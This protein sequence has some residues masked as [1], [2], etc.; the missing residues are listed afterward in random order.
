MI[1]AIC[2]NLEHPGVNNQFL[3]NSKSSLATLYN[4]ES[5]LEK[6][7]A[8]RAFELMLHPA[9]DLLAVFSKEEYDAFR[10]QVMSLILATD[11]ASHNEYV[12]S[13]QLLG[14]TVCTCMCMESLLKRADL[15]YIYIYMYIYIHIYM[16]IPRACSTWTCSSLFIFIFYV[17]HIYISTYIHIYTY[18]YMQICRACKTW[19]CSC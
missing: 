7:H 17:T 8:F 14:D 16:H 9:I 3:V 6:H 19:K 5:I 4:H 18:A 2:H 15:T 10:Q 11:L 1:A 13:L 12:A